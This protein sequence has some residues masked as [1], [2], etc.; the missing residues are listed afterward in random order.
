MIIG[1]IIKLKQYIQA[2]IK[3]INKRKKMMFLKKKLNKSVLIPKRPRFTKNNQN[4]G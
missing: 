2:K 3:R 1:Q 4:A